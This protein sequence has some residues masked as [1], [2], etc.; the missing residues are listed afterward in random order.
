MSEPFHIEKVITREQ[1]PGGPNEDPGIRLYQG[2]L[3]GKTFAGCLEYIHAAGYEAGEILPSNTDAVDS[4]TGR[5][6]K[7]GEIYVV[8][9]TK[10]PPQVIKKIGSYILEENNVIFKQDKII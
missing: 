5:I 1:F 8:D 6:N 4:L 3:P 2:Y 7:P 9:T 10:E